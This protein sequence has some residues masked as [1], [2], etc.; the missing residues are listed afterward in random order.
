MRSVNFKT[1]KKLLK[2]SLRE[3]EEAVKDYRSRAKRT[4]CSI[5][6]KQFKELAR[7]ESIHV[8]ELKQKIKQVEKKG[9]M[10]KKRG[11]R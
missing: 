6:K 1:T 3:E 10:I 7:D 5:A 11:R 9:K 4:K 2:K 8:K